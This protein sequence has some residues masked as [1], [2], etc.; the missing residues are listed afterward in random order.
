[1]L[2][3]G[4]EQGS[5]GLGGRTVDFV[6]KHHRSENG[7][8]DE[9]EVAFAVQ[10]LR[11]SDVGGHQVGGELNAAEGK[12]KGAGKGVDHKGF[13]QT[14]HTKEQTVSTGEKSQQEGVDSLMLSH[15]DFAHLVAESGIFLDQKVELFFICHNSTKSI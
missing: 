3:H 11:A 13:G 7:T 5:L 8:L 14:R 15:D 1:M 9:L 10:N 12:T 4:L 6:G 2:L